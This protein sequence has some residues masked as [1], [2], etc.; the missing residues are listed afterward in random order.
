MA[1]VTEIFIELE[2]YMKEQSSPERILF[3]TVILQAL[4]DASKPSTTNESERAKLDRTHAQ[5]WF[6]ASVGVT[7][8]GFSTV[9]DMAGVDP[10]YTRS[11]AYKVIR[12]KEVEY[13]RKKINSILSNI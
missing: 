7:A 1:A 6:F 2:D 3:M 9:C 13:T 8:E 11:F 10:G 12:S 5:A 4:L